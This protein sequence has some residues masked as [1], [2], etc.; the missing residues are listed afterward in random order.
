MHPPSP[1]EKSLSHSSFKMYDECP[2]RWLYHYAH[3]RL[4]ACVHAFADSDLLSWIAQFPLDSWQA[5]RP[6]TDL[7]PNFMLDDTKV[8][9][10][11]DFALVTDKVV[12]ILDWKTGKSDGRAYDTA[13]RQ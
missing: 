13:V 1:W 8:W 9:A 12:Y 11:P 5:P 6:P 3:N 4:P 10:A 7:A 2:R